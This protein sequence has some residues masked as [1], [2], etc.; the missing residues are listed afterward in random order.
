[1]TV[2]VMDCT[3]KVGGSPKPL[4]LLRTQKLVTVILERTVVRVNFAQALATSVRVNTR[5]QDV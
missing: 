2:T 1:M 4:L 3:A 5:V